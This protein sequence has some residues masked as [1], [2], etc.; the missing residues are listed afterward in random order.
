MTAVVGCAG[1]AQPAFAQSS[2]T[3]ATE[4]DMTEVVVT[5]ARVRSVGVV[6]QQ[7][8]AKSRISLTGEYLD[9]QTAGQ[10]VFQSINMIPGV[11]F[12]N[13]DPFGTSGGN[14][15][16]RG[17]DGSRVSVTFDGIPL[18]DSGNYALYTNQMLDP[19]LID[20]VDV[21]L[22]TTDV[23]SPTASATGGTVAYRTRRPQQE[24]GG[25]SVVSAGDDNYRRAFL[26]VDT[27]ELGPWGTTAFV[28]ASYQKYDKFKGP[29]EL[30]KKQFNA[31]VRQDFE[32]GDF[33]SLGMHYNVNRNAFYRAASAAS[34]EL[35]GRD[36]DNLAVCTLDPPTPGGIDNDNAT[37]VP[38]T[39][40]LPSGDNPANTSSCSNY[41][42]VRINPSDTGNIRMQSLWHLG[43]QVRL[44]FDPSWQY[45]LANGGGSTALAETPSPTSADI[46]VRGSSSLPGVDLNGDGDLL[47]TVRLYSPNT[48]NTKRWGATT[49]LIWDIDDDNRLRFA[50]TWD[51]ARHRQ[52]GM[53]GPLSE[54]GNPENVFAGRQGERIYA[55]DGDIIRGRDRFSIAELEQYALEWRGQFA[56]DKLA[57]TIGVRAPFF[58]REL[59][60]YCY[61]PNGGSG[62]SG[63]I[64]PRGGTLCTSRAPNATLANGNVT[65]VTPP[66][67]TPVEFIPPYSETVKFDDILPNAGITFSPWDRHMFYVSYAEG[68][69]APRTDNLYAVARD[70][71]TGDVVRP[72]PE[73]ET[74]K[75]YDIGWRLNDPNTIASLALYAIDYKNRIV[76]TFNQDLGYSEDRNVG[77]V[78]VKGFDAQIGRRFGDLLALAVSASYNDSELQGSLDP[79]L[80]GKQLVE[81]PEWTFAA[82]MDFKFTED[83]RAGLQAKYVGDRFSTDSNDER[84]PSYTVVDLDASY[85]FHFPGLKRAQVQLNVTNLLDE[86]YFGSISSG[87]GGNSVGFFYIGAPRTVVASLRFDF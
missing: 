24:F 75:A 12:T 44:T 37:P 61:T 40:A 48:T 46:R 78:D 67:G 49:S 30:E 43:D 29:G 7:T 68:L 79:T 11:N 58:T 20:R 50:Y 59:N 8:A 39:P 10:T 36:Y 80:D 52:T 3:E 84:A 18:N 13:N 70:P 71:A 17:F 87:T 38:S 64:G 23:D 73:S 5:A 76:S 27:G 21:N 81:T 16:I 25:Q 33:V 47:D 63:N 74:T 60:Q 32:N 65:F 86:E 83:L 45:T 19:E 31:M 41:Y 72:T 26:R 62:S 14:L 66:T 2:G 53:Y 42:G 6:N 69:S 34:Y 56:E 1:L 35:F 22:G 51:R 9:S 15:R 57:A 82:R 85:A 55:A 4:A 54:N 28:A 77:D